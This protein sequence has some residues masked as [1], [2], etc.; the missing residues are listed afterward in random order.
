LQKL[1]LQV[2]DFACVAIQNKV[3]IALDGGHR[4]AQFVRHNRR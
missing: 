1:A 2:V 3:D 4:R